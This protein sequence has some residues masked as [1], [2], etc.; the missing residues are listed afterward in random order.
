MAS[1]AAAGGKPERITNKQDLLGDFSD[2]DINVRYD[3][4][5]ATAAIVG[6]AKRVVASQRKAFAAAAVSASASPRAAA[7]FIAGG[8]YSRSRDTCDCAALEDEAASAAAGVEQVI[9]SQALAEAAVST[10]AAIAAMAA[11][12]AGASAPAVIVASAGYSAYRAVRWVGG[13]WG[14]TGNGDI[15]HDMCVQYCA[16]QKTKDNLRDASRSVPLFSWNYSPA[17]DGALNRSIPLNSKC[18]C[19]DCFMRAD[20]GHGL[21]LKMVSGQIKL[22]EL[23][24]NLD[25]KARLGIEC[26]NLSVGADIFSTEELDLLPPF[27]V[28]VPTQP[29]T[30]Y[31]F[32]L[33]AFLKF[34]ASGAIDHVSGAVM[35]SRKLTFGLRYTPNRGWYQLKQDISGGGWHVPVPT[36]DGLVFQAASVRLELNPNIKV[37]VTGVPVYLQFAVKP[38]FKVDVQTNRIKPAPRCHLDLGASVGATWDAGVG[39]DHWVNVFAKWTGLCKCPGNVKG[40]TPACDWPLPMVGGELIA[41]V[42]ISSSFG[43]PKCLV[44]AGGNHEDEL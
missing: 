41:E 22:F 17:R 39:F 8:S 44:P 19:K 13:L 42:D 18:Q 3:P 38:Y 7:V 9:I 24:L 33:G 15:T 32:S 4:A 14:W 36:I 30:T 35:F 20:I 16:L 10:A 34:G 26:D 2:V 40:E 23:K 37:Q 29:P 11:I 43:G 28:F 25:L 21:K 6:H 12:A 27:S 31:T 1:A 5:E